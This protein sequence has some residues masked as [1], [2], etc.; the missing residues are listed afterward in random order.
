MSGRRAYTADEKATATSLALEHGV[1]FAAAKTGIPANTIRG[2]RQRRLAGLLLD[3]TPQRHERHLANER[4]ESPPLPDGVTLVDEN[5][6]VRTPRT[7]YV[8]VARATG[9][10]FEDRG[11]VTTAVGARRKQTDS[12]H[13]RPVAAFAVCERTNV[14]LGEPPYREIVAMIPGYGIEQQALL[15]EVVHESELDCIENGGCAGHV[16]DLAKTPKEITAP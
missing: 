14:G 9:W 13:H 3:A 2:W 8:S 7:L 4:P 12:W 5:G 1:K 16:E 11:N 10:W 6:H 15:E